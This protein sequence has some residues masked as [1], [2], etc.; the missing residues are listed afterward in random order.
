MA[1]EWG[2]ATQEKVK[3]QL[4]AHDEGSI[5]LIIMRYWNSKWASTVHPEII[6]DFRTTV[7]GPLDDTVFYTCTSKD[8]HA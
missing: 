2:D 5:W 3:V 6:V 8:A 4:Y 7:T 1:Y